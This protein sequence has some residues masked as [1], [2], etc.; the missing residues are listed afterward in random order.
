M[1]KSSVAY[2]TTKNLL[3]DDSESSKKN[4]N[5]RKNTHS[6]HINMIKEVAESD[7]SISVRD[8]VDL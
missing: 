6:I 1:R 7:S 3:G 8:K 4:S 5:K 2:S